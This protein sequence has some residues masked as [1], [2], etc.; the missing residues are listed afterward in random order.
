MTITA[1]VIESVCT[2]YRDCTGTLWGLPVPMEGSE[3][4][5]ARPGDSVRSWLWLGTPDNFG[6]MTEDERD[7]V[8]E[9]IWTAAEGG[10]LPY[11]AG[12]WFSRPEGRPWLS[13]ST[14][15]SSGR[16]LVG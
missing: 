12:E 3:R 16:K 9:F 10:F 7:L 11:A 8:E 4:P 5:P 2:L 14:S 13:A 6:R 15:S 1:E